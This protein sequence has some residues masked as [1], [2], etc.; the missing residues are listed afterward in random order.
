MQADLQRPFDAS[1]V[2]PTTLRP[3][4]LQAVR[5]IYAQDLQGRIQILIGIDHG[6]DAAGVLPVLRAECPPHVALTVIDPG[7]STSQRHGGLYPNF[8]GG[9]LRTC[10]SYLANSRRVAY[11]DDDNW[12]APAH[13]SSLVAAIDG[14][15]WAHSL[16]VFV[17]SR[18]DT[19]LCN[20]DWE[21]V[22]PGRGLFNAQFGGF[23]D[24]NTL[25][26]DKLACHDVL[27]AW[28]MSP[29][30][31]GVGEDRVVFERIR[32]MPYGATGR[33]TAYYRYLLDGSN[34]FVTWRFMQAGVDIA[35]HVPPERIP[36]RSAWADFE[37]RERAL[38]ASVGPAGD[39]NA[40]TG[41]AR[42]DGARFAF[43]VPPR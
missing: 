13:L 37:R 18:L 20:D 24:T 30:A 38:T 22:G 3:S 23:V 17:D 32:G 29:F 1:V 9:A 4:L 35:R 26:L 36:P 2:V 34:P 12:W 27:P 16:R 25:M 43:T 31:G 41:A 40:G 42:F 8:F 7:Y 33:H 15:A 39:R 28:S 21:A 19:V 10:L 14:K 6:H 5:S 11:L